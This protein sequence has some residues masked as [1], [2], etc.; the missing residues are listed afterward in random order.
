VTV[1]GIVPT[2]NH[3]ESFNAILKR[4]HL[5]AWLY[6]RHRLHFDSLI[7]ILITQI[8]P[9]F[10]HHQAH[11]AYAEWLTVRFSGHAGGANLRNVRKQN[12]VDGVCG[13]CWWKADASRDAEARKVLQLGR[14][15]VMRG[16]DVNNSYRVVCTSSAADICDLNHLRYVV[17]VHRCG[18]SSC[19]CPEFGKNKGLACKHL[20]VLRLL[21]DCWIQAHQEQEFMFPLLPNQS[22]EIVQKHALHQGIPNNDAPPPM[23]PPMPVHR[24]DLSIIQALGRDNTTLDD[25]EDLTISEPLDTYEEGCNTDRSD[26]ASQTPP[27]RARMPLADTVTST[28]DSDVITPQPILKTQL[29]TDH[30]TAI[31]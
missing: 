7:H 16:T 17:D 15:A 20:R 11:K 2:T 31:A 4:K 24:M 5:P 13:L 18:I 22:R 23:A 3:L 10:N 12:L 21:I 28:A 30:R 9:I 29:G 27:L 6:S 8:L 25:Q 19:T 14:F 1:D 26:E